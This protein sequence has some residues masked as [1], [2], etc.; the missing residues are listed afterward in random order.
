MKEEVIKNIRTTN[1][2][3]LI[4]CVLFSMIPNVIAISWL[5]GALDSAFV[6]GIFQVLGE[7]SRFVLIVFALLA[8]FLDFVMIK[9]IYLIKNPLASKLF[10]RYGNI[11]EV[12]AIFDEIE[13]TKT[14]EDKHII[15]SENYIVH[16]KKYQQLVAFDDILSVYKHVQK[17]K[18]AVIFYSIVVVD[19]YNI[20]FGFEY[21][22]DQEDKV[23][24][25]IEVIG[26]KSKN[27]KVG[28][29][30]EASEHIKS[31]AQKLPPKENNM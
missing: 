13:A 30:D 2:K 12:A 1:V 6:S 16:K 15:M 14:Y 4:L 31:N 27:A 10:R 25:L 3:S 26:M 19:K 22:L 28:H 11:D 7:P 20:R 9:L 17:V 21:P 29:T 24:E 5:F 8:V 23:D 18:K